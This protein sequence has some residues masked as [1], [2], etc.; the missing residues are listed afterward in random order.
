MLETFMYSAFSILC[1][2]VHGP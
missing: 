2:S 1:A